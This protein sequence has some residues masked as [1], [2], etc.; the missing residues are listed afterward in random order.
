[1][2]PVSSSWLRF[3]TISFVRACL[4]FS[5]GWALLDRNYEILTSAVIGLGLSLLPDAIERFYSVKLPLRYA[6]VILGFVYAS[7]FLGEINYAYEHFLWWDTMLH[8]SAGIVCAYVGFLWLYLSSLQK[9]LVP[10]PWLMGFLTLCIG[11]AMAAVWEIFEF[12]MTDITGIDMQ[13]GGLLD[14]MTDIIVHTLGS[15]A[16]AI[17]AYFH[18]K[19]PEKSLMRAWVSRFTAVNPRFAAPTSVRASKAR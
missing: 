12:A 11:M 19:W 1:M 5:L 16:I 14:T 13:Y 8:A 15:F 7:M 9:K 6:L 10:D 3:L 4:L 17:A 18:M 2:F